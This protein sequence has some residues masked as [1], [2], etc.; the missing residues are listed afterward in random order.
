MILGGQ[1]RLLTYWQRP[2]DSQIVIVPAYGTFVL[3]HIEIGALVQK[4]RKLAQNQKAVRKSR[5]HPEHVMILL[6]KRR[7]HPLSKRR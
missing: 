4:V 2:I 3:R 7:P 5:R 1:E 6:G